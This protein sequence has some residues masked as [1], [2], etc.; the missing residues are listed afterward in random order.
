MTVYPFNKL[1]QQIGEKM[2]C[3]R[4]IW[5]PYKVKR[6]ERLQEIQ[7]AVTTISNIQQQ[8]SGRSWETLSETQVESETA[9][10]IQF[11]L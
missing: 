11:N 6:M 1:Y 4:D 3:Y 2:V 5:I 7:A 10:I 8:A 9:N